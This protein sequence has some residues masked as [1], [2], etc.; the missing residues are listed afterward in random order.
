MRSCNRK[1]FFVIG[2]LMIS[3]VAF[4]QNGLRKISKN[5]KLYELSVVWKELS[6]NFANVNHCPGLNMDSLYRVYIPIVQNTK[7]DFEYYKSLQQFL[8]HFH[9]GHTRCEMPDYFWDHLALPFLIT[10]YRNGKLLIDNIGSHYSKKITV[11]DEILK[12]D[13]MQAMEYIK[14]FGSAYVSSSNEDETLI[15]Y[16]MFNPDLNTLITYAPKEYKKKIRLE[17]KTHHG[18]ERVKIPFDIEMIPAPKDTAKQATRTFIKKRNSS[19]EEANVLLTDTLNSVAYLRITHCDNEFHSFFQQRY[20]TIKKYDNLIIDITG[21]GGGDG[22]A[23][24]DA[25]FCLVNTDS[26]Q[27]SANK[28]RVSNAY[29][30]ARASFDHYYNEEKISQKEK[31]LYD[32]YFF[33]TAFMEVPFPVY[34]NPVSPVDRY[35]GN[36]YVLTSSFTASAAEYFAASLKKN[37]KT[38][39]IGTK[40]AGATA[41]PLV[42]RLPSGIEVRIN[43]CK[44]YDYQGRDISSGITPDYEYNFSDL[45]QVGKSNGWFKNVYKY[46]RTL[47][48][49]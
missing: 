26:I 30:R 49:Q 24:I 31:D 32:P 47:P 39:L 11:D 34:A 23:L 3:V 42:V 7:N 43:T 15:K 44:S 36:I 18:I 33:D 14:K 45:Y 25:I 6:Y 12:I 37:S 35:R 17:V 1:I 21:N 9:N 48:I 5:Q 41:Q 16:S 8:A 20:E 22:N 10:T 46:I 28:T 27:W 38:L 2:G 19:K 40:T 4:S 29:Y 13:D